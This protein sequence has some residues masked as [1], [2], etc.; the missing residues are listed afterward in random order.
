MGSNKSQPLRRTRAGND[1]LPAAILTQPKNFLAANE[2]GVLLT[3]NGNIG[4]SSHELLLHS[5]TL[6]PHAA[7]WHNL[8]VV[9]AR[10]GER[11]LAELAEKR[12]KEL[13]ESGRTIGGPRVKWVDPETFA[14]TSSMSDSV[15][16]PAAAAN[17]PIA[18]AAPGAAAGKPAAET[19]KRGVSDW[20]PRNLRR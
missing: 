6:W 12:A 11:E 20:I 7:T 13:A 9:H 5:A 3:E 14:S 1:V 19:A 4:R 2:L 16:P 15:M 8:A 17:S 10:L 18:A